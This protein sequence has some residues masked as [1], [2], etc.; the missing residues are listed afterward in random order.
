MR[1]SL[2][3][4]TSLRVFE[5]TAKHSSLDVAA[6]KLFVTKAAVTKQIRILESY[7][8]IRLFDINNGI[9]CLT[10]EGRRY[11]EEIFEAFEKLELASKKLDTKGNA[12]KV[13]M[14]LSPSL[15]TLWMTQH[16]KHLQRS[17]PSLHL[18]VISSDTAIDW[19]RS[20]V[21]IAVRCFPIE[22]TKTENCEF[23]ARE[24]L[25]LISNSQDSLA[26]GKINLIS[27]LAGR[28]LISLYNRQ[29]LWEDLFDKYRVNAPVN[30]NIVCFEHFYMVMEAV[31]EGIGVGL[32]PDF[33]CQHLINEG[34]LL[35]PLSIS[36]DTHFGYFVEMPAHKQNSVILLKARKYIKSIFI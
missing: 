30:S 28:K 11:Y 9:L 36:I 1:R 27:D 26:H 32:V 18:N 3:P 5:E 22:H 7:L 13:T 14:D 15:C 4:L 10:E 34:L 29:N 19:S 33:L 2:P 6:E 17:C 8:E 21:D 35:N 25:I 16:F 12:L 20:N 24:K 23:L 31:K